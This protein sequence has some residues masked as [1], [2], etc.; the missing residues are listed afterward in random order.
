MHPDVLLKHKGIRELFVAD[1]ALVK[2]A[3][4]RFDSV[5]SH[6]CLEIPFSG[7]RAAANFAA[8]GSFT[9]V[10]PVVHLQ[11]AAATEHTMTYHALVRVAQLVLD[12]VHQLL[13]LGGLRRPRHLHEGFPRV[14]VTSRLWQ[15]VLVEGRI[16]VEWNRR[17]SARLKSRKRA[18]YE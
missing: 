7:K 11:G 6:V 9:C 3:Q 2:Y 15:Q 16:R 4:R 1:R 13:Q 14:V 12:V 10:C 5:H 17:I 18:A 8:K